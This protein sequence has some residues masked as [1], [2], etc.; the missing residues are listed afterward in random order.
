[1]RHVR[2]SQAWSS[3][4]DDAPASHMVQKRVGAYDG[5]ARA[6]SGRSSAWLEHRVWDAEV[7]GSNPAAPIWSQTAEET[8]FSSAT[9]Y[10]PPGSPPRL[11]GDGSPSLGEARP[12]RGP[13]GIARR[14]RRRPR[15][16]RRGQRGSPD[17]A[18][19]LLPLRP[20]ADD[21]QAPRRCGLSLSS[22]VYFGNYSAQPRHGVRAL[23]M[24]RSPSKIAAE[25]RA[26]RR[27]ARDDRPARSCRLDALHGRRAPRVGALVRALGHRARPALSRSP[28]FRIRRGD[29]AAWQ[30]DEILDR[31]SRPRRVS[32][33]R[34][35]PRDLYGLYEGREAGRMV[36]APPPARLGF[37]PR[38]TDGRPP[39]P[40]SSADQSEGLLIPRSQ[41]RIL[42]GALK[43]PAQ[44]GFSRWRGSE[45]VPSVSPADGGPLTTAT[46]R[47]A[48]IGSGISEDD[49]W[50]SQ[51]HGPS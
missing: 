46:L 36:R 5:D 3:S 23:A 47:T 11:R 21:R 34:L 17:P 8:S 30:F 18:R 13:R 50:S 38:M 27:E 42:P 15:A 25:S 20:L 4:S 37:Q 14:P 1:M 49:C 6:T 7:A 41:V 51:N 12:D 24:D 45:R 48:Q 29:I 19:G 22:L 9:S 10:D 26:R 39:G 31:G 16:R 33:P 32:L 40:R 2:S 35:H 28:P 43:R 44:A